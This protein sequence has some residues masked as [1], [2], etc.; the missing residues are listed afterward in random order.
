MLKEYSYS[1]QSAS[2]AKVIHLEQPLC[3]PTLMPASVLFSMTYSY[4]GVSSVRSTDYVLKS[5]PYYCL[6]ALSDLLAFKEALAGSNPAA[7]VQTEA[8]CMES[9]A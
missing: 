7:S 6:P 5:G 3:P 4:F 1:R 2:Q 9:M 8:V